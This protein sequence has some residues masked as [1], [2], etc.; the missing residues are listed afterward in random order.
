MIIGDFNARIGKPDAKFSL[1]DTANR[2]GQHLLDLLMEKELF[3]TNFKFQKT[4][5]NKCQLDYTLANKKWRK[6]F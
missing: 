5:G 6:A 3:I 1:H 4:A 2:N